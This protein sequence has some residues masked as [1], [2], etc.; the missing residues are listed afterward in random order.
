[1]KKIIN[2][3]IYDT[4]SADKLASWDNGCFTNDFYYVSED[5]YKTSKGEY[6]LFGEGGAASKYHGTAGNSSYGTSDIIPLSK[7]QAYEW[8]EEHNHIDVIQKEF[9]D[10]IEEA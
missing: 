5:L 6:F 8:C 7:E 4:D 2:K 1:M 9:Q 3:K 10:Y